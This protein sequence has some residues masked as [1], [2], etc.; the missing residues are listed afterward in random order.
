[1]AKKYT[2]TDVLEAARE[3][4]RITFDNFERIYC[5][6][7]GGKDSTVTL[8]LVMD[9]AIKRNRKV[10]VLIIDLEAQYTE[11]I[12]HIRNIISAYK[13]NIKL[14]WVAVPLLLRNAVTNFEPRWICW[15]EDNKDIWVRE[16]PEEAI[17]EKDLPFFVPKMEF[18][19]FM[20]LFGKYYGNGYPVAAFIG[21]RADE[22]LH[23]YCAIATWKKKGLM[24]NDYRWTTRIVDQ[25]FNIYPIYDWKTED[26]WRYH[27][28]FPEKPYN[29]IYDKMQMAGVKLSQQ[30]L[31]QPYGDDQRRGLWLYHILEPETW[32]K[33][34]ARVN[35]A[36]SG[37]LY[38]RE[39][40]NI[41]GYHKI[42][43]PD[44]HTWKSFCNLLLQTMPKKTR[45]HYLYRFKKFIWGWKQRG[46][47]EVPDES[48]LELENKCWA[49]SWR[50]MC[51]TL[52]RNDYWCKGLGQ[53]QPKSEAY[54]KYLEIKKG[55]RQTQKQLD[56]AVAKQLRLFN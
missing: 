31:C 6:F 50:R 46:Y 29:K 51:K 4:I 39:N 38:I 32:F 55:S 28:T 48:P 30:R 34:I 56:G 41:T 17:E 12:I 9:E 19:E 3:R 27:A 21:I 1:M 8:H 2:E 22:S 5:S 40:G 23:R 52:L 11:T 43:K 53:A 54:G 35:G 47:D 16:K 36:N 44:H 10:G 25:C 20:V 15:D 42:T 33:L 24:F 26:V 45:D 14:Y 13:D 18:E 49:P 7:S 37:A